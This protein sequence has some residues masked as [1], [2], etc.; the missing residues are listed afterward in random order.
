MATNVE[1]TQNAYLTPRTLKVPFDEIREPGCYIRNSSGNLYR[2]PHEA[3]AQGRSPLIE[4][5]AHEGTMMTKVCDDPWVP[6]SKA[7]Q[8]AADADLF[9]NF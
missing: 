3:L 4:I 2:V 8:L 9:V 5:V 1:G 6:I 7:R